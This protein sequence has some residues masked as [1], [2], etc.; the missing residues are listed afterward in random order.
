MRY[1]SQAFQKNDAYYQGRIAT[2]IP[3]ESVPVPVLKQIFDRH[4]EDS[5]SDELIARTLEPIL[6]LIDEG[7]YIRHRP[8]VWPF[9]RPR[10]QKRSGNRG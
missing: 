2:I 1:S 6:E 5:F 9:T 7:V 8:L 10:R 4:K 3:T